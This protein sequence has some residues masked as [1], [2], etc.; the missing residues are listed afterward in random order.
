MGGGGP[1]TV[2]NID[3]NFELHKTENAWKPVK[4]LVEADV[5]ELDPLQELERNVRAILNKLTPQKFDKLVKQ[6][7]DL[8][9]DT[10]PKLEACIELIFEKVSQFVLFHPNPPPRR[11]QCYWAN[12]FLLGL[13]SSWTKSKLQAS[14]SQLSNHNVHIG[15]ILN[16]E[17]TSQKLLQAIAVAA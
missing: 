8:T 15:A 9:I 4:L 16:L 14:L 17:P 2:I 7:I 1:P 11:P 5:V 3:R 12:S 6:F 13:V 10:E